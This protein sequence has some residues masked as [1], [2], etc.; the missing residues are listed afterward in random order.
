MGRK[1]Y[2]SY[3]NDNYDNNFERKG[4]PPSPK[5]RRKRKVVKIIS[6]DNTLDSKN[7]VVCERHWTK[8]YET[9]QCYGKLR[10]RHPP[11]VFTLLKL[12]P[13]GAPKRIRIVY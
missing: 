9:M 10:P 2:V 13:D 3:C 5:Q 8:G 6:R 7:T 12:K 11:S 1:Y 4:F